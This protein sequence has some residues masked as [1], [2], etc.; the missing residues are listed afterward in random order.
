MMHAKI[1]QDPSTPDTPPSAR[2]VRRGPTEEHCGSRGRLRAVVALV[3][4]AHC[5][6]GEVPDAVVDRASCRTADYCDLWLAHLQSALVQPM[7]TCARD[8]GRWSTAY[9][10][11]E[12]ALGSCIFTIQISDVDGRITQRSE[13]IYRSSLSR[14]YLEGACRNRGG[15]WANGR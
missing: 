8:E 3:A 2:G 12:G 9:C 15:Q 6:D 5:G 1:S 10:P 14:E 4:L 13:T 11:A 7:M